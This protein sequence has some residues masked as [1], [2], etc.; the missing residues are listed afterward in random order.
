MR[1]SFVLRN[2]AVFKMPDAPRTPPRPPHT[3][4]DCHLSSHLCGLGLDQWRNGGDGESAGGRRAEG[5]GNEGLYKEEAAL[6]GN[7]LRL[8]P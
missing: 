8:A 7:W 5:G 1:F 3:T 2:N 6:D 4:Y